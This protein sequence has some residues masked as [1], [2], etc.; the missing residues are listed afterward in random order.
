MPLLRPGASDS[1]TK[2][3][4]EAVGRLAEGQHGV[5]SRRQLLACG[6]SSTMVARWLDAGR[7]IRLHPHVYALGHSVLTIRGRLNAA[8][9]Y[10]GDQAALSHT[11]A[12]WVWSLIDAEPSRIHLTTPGRLSSL[13]DV[14]VH[15]TRELIAMS[16]RGHRVTSVARTLLD[17]GGMVRF[18]ELRRA[19][20]EADFRGLLEP[21]ELRS[22]LK[23]GRRGSRALRAALDIHLPQLAKTLSVLEERFLELCEMAGLPV[24]EANAPVGG[25]MVDALWREQRLIVELDG[26]AAHGGWSQVSRDRE[27]ELALRRLGF[28]VVRY[29]WHQVANQPTDV[30]V[31]LRRELLRRE[32]PAERG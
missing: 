10:G 30:A 24:P 9:L 27:R 2:A 26:A 13:P 31:D 12:A 5:I 15:R 17:L 8:L 28:R 1:R 16:C 3:D 29:T 21:A 14:R 23:K 6:L 18:S 20:A 32:A 7:L 11:T 25:M 4:A 19:L 22:V